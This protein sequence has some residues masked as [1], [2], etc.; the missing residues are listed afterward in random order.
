MASPAAEFQVAGRIVPEKGRL[1]LTPVVQLP[2]EYRADF[3]RRPL[4]GSHNLHQHELF[5][6]AALIDLLDHFPRQ[7]LYALTMGDDLTRTDDNRLALHDGVSGAELLRAVKN[8]RLWLNITRVD[9]A[10]ARYRALI[11]QLYA[12]LAAQAPGFSPVASQGT[13]LVSSPHA[14]VYYHADGP[15]SMLWH[16]RGRKR[17]WIYPALD[18]RYMQREFLEDI[19]A[20]VRH[21]YLPYEHAYDQAAVIYDLEPGQW[22]TWPQNAPHRVTNLDSVNVS[23]STEHFTR[24]SRWRA[25]VYTANRFFRTRL[26]LRNLSARENGPAA[27]MKTVVH[28]MAGKAG[29]DPLR[30]KRH[31]ASMRVDPDAPGGVV[32]LEPM[33]GSTEA[34]H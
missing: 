15:A 34:S 29:L 13:L 22:A 12:Q 14:L 1:P 17:I 18:E 28:R 26:G 33:S 3:G 27:V 7:H 10:D 11:D 5:S 2:A 31:V 23:L 16:I 19:F 30:I 20:G 6:D 32:A 24:Q 25:R 8:G 9:R 21:E 4:L